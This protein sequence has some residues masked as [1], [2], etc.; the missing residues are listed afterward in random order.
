MTDADRSKLRTRT[1]LASAGR[2][3]GEQF[4]F[5]NTPIYRGSTVLYP[6]YAD[7]LARNA[8]Y[9][10][11]THG[12]P[13]VRALEEAWSELA[14]AEATVLTPSG[15]AAITVA[16]LSAVKAGDH[17]L[18]MDS[19][20]RPTRI[21]CD[22][23]LKRMGVETTYFDP[24]L[25][26]EVAGLV[27]DNTSVLFLEA[28]GSQSFEV[29]DLPAYVAV[30]R[31]RDLCTILDNTWATP[32]YLP[33]HALGIDI[34]AEAGTKYLSGHSDLLLGLTSANAKWAKRLRATFDSF[35]MC[36]GPEDAFLGLRG[37]RTLELRL[38]E[39]QAQGLAM[40]HWLA[41]RPEVARVLHPAFPDCPGHD[42]WKRD[43]LGATGLFSVILA[44]GPEAAVASLLDGLE[45][46]GMGFSW[47]GYESLVVPFD[48]AAYRSATTW[49][50]GGPGLRF[51]IGLEDVADLQ[52]D[53]DAGFGRWRAAGGG[54]L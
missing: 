23:V 5:V 43:F 28:P 25:G 36:T 48:C 19:V 15:L 44:P 2:K 32:L 37:L 54:C 45:L 34:A 13:T 1:R 33:P 12:T 40:A 35:A 27:R 10:Y 52:A 53:L 18:V 22:G 49:A 8:P 26:A 11:A 51:S 42:F 41:A 30:A 16:I 21:F 24:M 29:P 39:A 46:F 14:G 17:I 47:G 7:L 3:P 31:D 6:T 50:P 20:Y 38:R 9:T 4:G